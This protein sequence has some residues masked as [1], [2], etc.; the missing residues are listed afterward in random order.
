MAQRQLSE[1]AK[2]ASAFGCSISLT[3]GEK[4][5]HNSRLRALPKSRGVQWKLPAVGAKGIH[6]PRS[7]V[8]TKGRSRDGLSGQVYRSPVPMR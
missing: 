1:P 6:R 5:A 8:V 2:K 3:R 7:Q 4:Q